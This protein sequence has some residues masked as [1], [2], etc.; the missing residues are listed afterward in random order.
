MKRDHIA[1]LISETHEADGLNQ[2]VPKEHPREV[3]CQISSVRQSEW[4]A[5]GQAGLKPQFVLTIFADDYGDEEIV[6]VDGVR[7]GVYRTYQ[8]GS[9]QMEL[10]LERKG[11]V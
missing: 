5:A 4:F 10:Y 1:T 7:Y 6:E 9:H 8:A 2:M 11:G 3:F